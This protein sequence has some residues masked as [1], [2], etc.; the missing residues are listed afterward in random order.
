MGL[1]HFNPPYKGKLTKTKE[2]LGKRINGYFKDK[3]IQTQ[4]YKDGAQ[5]LYNIFALQIYSP[6]MLHNSSI[7]SPSVGSEGLNQNISQHMEGQASSH[8]L[9][10]GENSKY[11]YFLSIKPDVHGW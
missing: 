7:Y 1:H 11:F 3:G 6:L 9:I 8:S 2:S 10:D 4:A 5:F